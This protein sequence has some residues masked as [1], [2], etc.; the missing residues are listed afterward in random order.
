MKAFINTVFRHRRQTAIVLLLAFV[1]SVVLCL[2]CFSRVKDKGISSISQSDYSESISE[3]VSEA[4][5]DFDDF[6][7]S[8][9]ASLEDAETESSLDLEDIIIP[10]LGT[11]E[12]EIEMVEIGDIV[13]PVV[14][15]YNEKS[16]TFNMMDGALYIEDIATLLKRYAPED[17]LISAACAIA[18]TEG[19]AGKSGV[20][21]VTNNCFGLRAASTWDGYVFARSTGRVYKDYK[22]AVAYQAYDLFRAYDSMEESVIDFINVMENN[23]NGVLQSETPKAFFKYLLARGY[24][25]KDIFSTW[26][27][28]VN[29]YDITQHDK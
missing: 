22:T 15:L 1:V 9:E 8:D 13:S 10:E 2:L 18:Y 11:Y 19:G 20:Y 27:Y 25:N 4:V 6:E 7:L 14:K 23:Y 29:L 28:L 26:M 5:S 24:G 17:M 21:T 16:P 12:E 3:L